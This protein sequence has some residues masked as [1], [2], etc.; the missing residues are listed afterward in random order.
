MTI[1]E[2]DVAF[3]PR[4]LED[5]HVLGYASVVVLQYMGQTKGKRTFGPVTG[6][7]YQIQAR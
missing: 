1:G 5:S 6:G 7:N 3:S 4:P 2:S